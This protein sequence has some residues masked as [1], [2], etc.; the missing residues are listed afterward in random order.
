V[1]VSK[2][3][4]T[5]VTAMLPWQGRMVGCLDEQLVLY[6]LNRSLA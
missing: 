1:T 5:Y 2:A 3:S 6:T 4:T